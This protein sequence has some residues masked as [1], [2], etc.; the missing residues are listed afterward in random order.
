VCV[1][2]GPTPLLLIPFSTLSP[3]KKVSRSP[4]G[5][6][7]SQFHQAAV[8]H[9]LI[10][11][12]KS[13]IFFSFLS[14][15]FPFFLCLLPYKVRITFRK[16]RRCPWISSLALSFSKSHTGQVRKNTGHDRSGITEG[17]PEHVH[18]PPKFCE[19][20]F[21]L[22]FVFI[23]QERNYKS[24]L[25]FI[26]ARLWLESLV[27]YRFLPSFLL[28]RAGPIRRANHLSLPADCLTSLLLMTN[29]QFSWKSLQSALSHYFFRQN[30]SSRTF[31]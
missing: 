30:I 3:L 2:I 18:L 26:R 22:H 8:T 6:Y 27:T 16:W 15:L 31:S 10:S 21:V 4:M 5:K 25:G 9:S 17:H 23:L 29:L 13:Y 14:L 7:V 19:W 24:G 28:V 20:H 1:N 11:N 12:S